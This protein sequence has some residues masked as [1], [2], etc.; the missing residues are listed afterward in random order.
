MNLFKIVILLIG[1]LFINIQSSWSQSFNFKGELRD[2]NG[3]PIGVL[4]VLMSEYGDIDPKFMNLDAV[5]ERAIEYTT[6]PF[7]NSEYNLQGFLFGQ[8]RVSKNS[9]ESLLLDETGPGPSGYKS[10]TQ[11]DVETTITHYVRKNSGK[12]PELGFP[13]TFSYSP[14]LKPVKG[15]IW[16]SAK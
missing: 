8:S 2:S 15:W 3:D 5:K 14:P 6:T 9:K 11:F 4:N 10:T 16:E 1:L 13:D 7:F 12:K